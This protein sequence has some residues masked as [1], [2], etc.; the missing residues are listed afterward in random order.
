MSRKVIK[1]PKI[2]KTKKIREQEFSFKS[3]QISKLGETRKKK[4]AEDNKTVAEMIKNDLID[5]KLLDDYS[6]IRKVANG[7]GWAYSRLRNA[8]NVYEE[9]G[10]RRRAK[11][12]QKKVDK[13]KSKK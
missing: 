7:M 13:K 4:K 11:R 2:E 8:V 9:E 6:Y 5:S 3:I 10:R 1:R 12:D